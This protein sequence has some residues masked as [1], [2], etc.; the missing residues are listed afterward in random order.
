MDGDLAEI[1]GIHT[2]DGCISKNERYS[3]YYLGGDIKEEKEYHDEWVSYLFNKKVMMPLLNKKVIYKEHP[4]VGV[5]G[6]Y[7]FNDKIVNFFEKKGMCI[8]TKIGVRV[9]EEIMKNKKF[10]LRFLRGLF[11]TDGNIYFDKNRS[12]KK[13]INKIPLIK[14]DS[15]SKNLV[16]D[17][18]IMLKKLGLNP[19]LKKPYQGK[20]DKN[21]VHTVLLYRKND[22]NYFI[23]NIGFKNPKH[24][25]KWQVFKKLGYCLP[26]TTLNQRREILLK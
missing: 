13:P 17:V 4:K 6:F 22:V 10:S 23:D 25:T 16:G 19:R 24:Y 7:I 26:R 11:D 1:L 15:V 20:R 18:F 2:G 5:Y 12:C 21:K 8:G 3:E 14:V 9:P